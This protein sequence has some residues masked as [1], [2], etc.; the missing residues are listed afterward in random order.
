MQDTWQVGHHAYN[1]VLLRDPQVALLG[2]R[3]YVPDVIGLTATL[4]IK[5]HSLCRLLSMLHCR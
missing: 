4:R 3:T 1:M 2:R 5:P